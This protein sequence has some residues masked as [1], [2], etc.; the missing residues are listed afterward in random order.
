[1]RNLCTLLV[2][3]L[4]SLGLLAAAAGQETRKANDP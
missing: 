4:I 3:T 1:M 2:T